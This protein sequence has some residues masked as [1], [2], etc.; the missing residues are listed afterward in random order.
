[1]RKAR[2]FDYG[3]WLRGSLPRRSFRNTRKDD[4]GFL[5]KRDGRLGGPREVTTTLFLPLEGY[6]SGV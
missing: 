1:M 5:F 2:N 3:G 6:G 4:K